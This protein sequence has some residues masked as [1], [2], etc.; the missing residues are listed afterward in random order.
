MQKVVGKGGR[1]THIDSQQHL[2]ALPGMAE[3]ISR[4]AREFNV[5]IDIH[6]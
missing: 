4:V 1:I 2:H 6:R 5:C 3:V